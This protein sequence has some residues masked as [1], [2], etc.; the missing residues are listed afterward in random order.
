L[1][2]KNLSGLVIDTNILFSTL[3]KDG[4]TRKLFFLLEV[5][6][7]A[8]DFL[9]IELIKNKE[10]I[11]S[12]SS[13]NEIEFITIA[14]KIFSRINFVNEKII[15]AENRTKAYEICKDVDETD[16]PF[17]ALA[18]ELAL[19]LWSGDKKL[20]KGLKDKNFNEIL[21]NQDLIKNDFV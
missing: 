14:Y 11:L 13:M 4:I 5:E 8:P 6:L 16:T 18:L 17:I 15:S 1:V 9:M 3:Q 19:P 21:T 2:S 10:K 12:L 20:A 7:Y